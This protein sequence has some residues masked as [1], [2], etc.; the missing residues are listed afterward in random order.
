MTKI[1]LVRILGNDLPPRHERGQ[2]LRNLKFIVENEFPFEGVD[3]FFVLNKIANEDQADEIFDYLSETDQ[4]CFT[5]CVDKRRYQ[6][7]D[8]RGRGEYLTS[9]N[10]ARNFC[11]SKL[12]DYDVVFP[13]DGN[14]YF[15]LDGWLRTVSSFDVDR[16]YVVVQMARTDDYPADMDTL[17]NWME[18]YRWADKETYAPTEPQIGFIR[19]YDVTYDPT[20]A[21]GNASKLGLL[22]QIGVPGVWDNWYPE[23]KAKKMIARSKYYGRLCHGGWCYRLPSGVPA[24]E[25]DNQLRAEARKQGIAGLVADVNKRFG[26]ST[27][28]PA[29]GKIPIGDNSGCCGGNGG[30]TNKKCCR[31]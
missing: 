3:K 6:Y 27:D 21:Y 26:K 18:T 7:L 20:L 17:P 1:A 29:Q 14:C 15:R 28:L 24:C 12:S 31:T 16:P 5:I 2:T 10:D 4:R 25:A 22:Y 8:D 19:G 9:V 30:K 11:L 23:L 13:L